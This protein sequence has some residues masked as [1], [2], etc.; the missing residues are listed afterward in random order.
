MYVHC[1]SK[2]VLDSVLHSLADAM[3]VEAP[4]SARVL[5]CPFLGHMCTMEAEDL[6]TAKEG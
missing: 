3:A 5:V 1:K 2:Q 6:V 4:L